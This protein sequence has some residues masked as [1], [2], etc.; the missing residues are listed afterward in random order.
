LEERNEKTLQELRNWF[1]EEAVCIPW[2][3]EIKD[4]I[5]KEE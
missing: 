2:T 3:K 5:V 4:I 1:Y